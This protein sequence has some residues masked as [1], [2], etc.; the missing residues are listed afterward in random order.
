MLG[1]DFI[2][3]GSKLRAGLMT[4]DTNAQGD[5]LTKACWPPVEKNHR[6]IFFIIYRKS[7]TTSDL[8]K[9]FCAKKNMWLAKDYHT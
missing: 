3:E 4:P 1:D 9:L 8:V 6:D 7:I 2:G 5:R